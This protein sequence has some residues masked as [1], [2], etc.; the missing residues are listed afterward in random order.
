VPTFR[1]V[2]R[3]TSAPVIISETGIAPGAGKVATL[4]QLFSGVRAQ[5]LLGFVYFDGNQPRGANYHYR[6][7]LEESPAAM[8]EY[9]TLSRNTTATAKM[10]LTRPIRLPVSPSWGVTSAEAGLALPW[11]CPANLALRR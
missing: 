5:H 4:Q 9:A 3:I 8:A 11:P 6:W 1:N 2:R 10:R 7:R